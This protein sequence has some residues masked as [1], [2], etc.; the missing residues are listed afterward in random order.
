MTALDFVPLFVM[1]EETTNATNHENN[2]PAQ[3]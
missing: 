3:F 2:M 1:A